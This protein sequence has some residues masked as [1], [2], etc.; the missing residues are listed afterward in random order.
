VDNLLKYI[1]R[2]GKQGRI[3]NPHLLGSTEDGRPLVPSGSFRRSMA[4]IAMAAMKL[5][6]KSSVSGIIRRTCSIQVEPGDM[7][8]ITIL[9]FAGL[10]SCVVGEIYV[11]LASLAFRQIISIA[12]TCCCVTWLSCVLRKLIELINESAVKRRGT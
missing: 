6:R 7:P 11:A 10:S 8:G 4:G 9:M 12:V 1:K 3:I 2:L 5:R